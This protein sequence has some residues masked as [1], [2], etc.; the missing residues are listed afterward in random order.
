MSEIDRNPDSGSN[1][2]LRR[3]RTP[4]L[5]LV[6]LA[7]LG[8]LPLA[9]VWQS[10]LA[11]GVAW[12]GVATALNVWQGHLGEMSFGH[13]AFVAV[14][15]YTWTGARSRAELAPGTALLI[16]LAVTLAVCAVVGLAVVQLSHFGSAI[17]TLFL[18]FVVAAGLQSA[19]FAS[20]TGSQAGLLVPELRLLGLDLGAG[21]GL[22]Y[23]GLAFLGAVL[24][25]TANYVSGD[26][27]KAL[28]L[29]RSDPQVATLLGVQVKR[30]T[31]TAFVYTGVGAAL[32]GIVL[33][34]VLT[35]VTPDSFAVHISITAVAM[36]VV[37]GQGTTV[38]PV[39]GA[40]FFG[41]LPVAF[42]SS[43]VNQALYASAAFLAFLIL[44]PAGIVGL[45]AGLLRAGSHR[46]AGARARPTVPGAPGP[47]LPP[48][49]P[50]PPAERPDPG[51]TD[52]APRRRTAA[53]EVLGV[54]VTFS[55]VHALRNVTDTLPTGET[56]ALIGP[57][58][59]GKSTLINAITGIQPV[60]AGVIK[61]F[62]TDVTRLHPHRIR[63]AGVGRTFQNPSLVGGLSVL[64]NVRLG[65]YS[66]RGQ[67]FAWDLLR[68]SLSRRSER[69]AVARCE[70]ALSQVGL[71]R[72]LWSEQADGI[73]LA[74]RKLVDLARALVSRPRVLLLDEPTAGLGEDEMHVVENALLGLRWTRQVSILLIAHHVAFVRRVADSV[75]VLDAGEVL[76]TGSPE[77]VTNDDAVLEAFVGR[78]IEHGRSRGTRQ[79]PG[80]SSNR[81]RATGALT[82]A[83][84]PGAA[85]AAPGDAGPG[86]VVAHLSA[87]Y[88]LARVLDDVSLS[89]RRGEMVGLT[90][91]NG[92]GK[93]TLLRSL[94]G[95]SGRGAAAVTLDG[96]PLPR[97]PEAVARA[98]LIHVPEGRGVI[99][100][101][102][103]L[104]N[105]R[106]GALAVGGRLTKDRLAE[107]V[108]RFP[109][110]GPLLA[111]QAGLLSGGQQ[112][113]LAIA[114]GLVADPAVLMIDELSLGLSP[115]ATGEALEAVSAITG[116][117]GPGVLVVDQSIK[118]LASV[119]DRLYVLK[120]G[121]ASEVESHRASTQDLQEVYF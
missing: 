117:G 52:T 63:K 53:V 96:T 86:L 112:Q 24:F 2:P 62:G 111:R 88:G 87:G 82:P 99:P 61:V 104:E 17:V 32:G 1:G 79:V 110:L 97:R 114:R 11:A 40:F 100:S 95:L 7:V 9:A 4:V 59:A 56:H 116:G 83:P 115:K 12:A 45:G 121:T 18:A 90:G 51:A 3:Y 65:L 73:S 101:L 92:V 89:V 84:A 23:L 46:F 102:T 14:G 67:P 75:T 8:A 54:D 58:G 85:A 22:Y 78:P 50:P 93:S 109:A 74:D 91:R 66:Q 43:P 120:N 39:L 21:R 113:M 81:Q 26:R 69:Q 98:G 33:A 55:G 80:A 29:I 47:R 25:L 105:L 35:V 103:V 60:A 19:E 107:T 118:T 15:A 119:C 37:G 57:N 68:G 72:R 16:T 77:Q 13:G 48:D 71:A 42:Q 49:P 36:I 108:E 94:S 34:Q 28:R 27:G 106:V 10:V 38:G 64:E 44:A 20:V 70:D 6:V 5:L 76:A 31:W 30:V 41:A